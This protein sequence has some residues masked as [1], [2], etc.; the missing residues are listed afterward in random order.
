[1]PP[2]LILF[3]RHFVF[4]TT[5]LDR[6]KESQPSRIVILTSNGH[7]TT[8]AGGIDFE[9]L[10]Q[11]LTTVNTFARYGQSKLANILYGKALARRLQNDRVYVNMAHP[12]FTATEL[13]R[14]ASESFGSFSGVMA[15]AITKLVGKDPKQGAMTQLYL[16]TSPEVEEKDIRAK[17]FVPLAQEGEPSALAKDELLQ[18]KLWTFSE[19][20]VKEK[21]GDVRDA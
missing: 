8:A 2:R 3:Y 1:M 13:N 17:Y 10:H 15:G 21:I 5:L 19:N 4:T 14:H 20:L 16:A 6:I 12:G 7:Q 9:N 11:E 18:E